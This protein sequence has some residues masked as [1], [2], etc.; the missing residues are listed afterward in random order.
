MVDA[1]LLRHQ[2]DLCADE[3][4]H[5]LIS[6]AGVRSGKTFA[7]CTKALKLGAAN[8]DLPILFVEPTYRM[9]K[10]VAVR[11]FLDIFEMWGIPYTYKKTDQIIRPDIMHEDGQGYGFDI[12]L[13]SAD[14]A[15]RLMGWTAA[16]AILDEAG[17]VDE[18][19]PK[20]LMKRVSHPL[21]KVRQLVLC[22]TPEGFNW[23]YEWAEGTPKAGSRLIRARTADNRHL[24]ADYLDGVLSYLS[25]EEIAQYT[26]GLFVPMGG[27]V[28]HRFRRDLHVRPCPMN[29]HGQP[30]GQVQMWC[31]F[32]I[33]TQAWA[34]ARVNGGEAHVFDEVV[35]EGDTQTHAERAVA[36]LHEYGIPPSIVDVYC[37]ATGSARKTSSTMSDVLLLKRAGFRNVL[38]NKANPPVRD[39]VAAVNLKLSEGALFFDPKARY[40][41]KC[42]EQQGRDE[43]GEPDKRSGLDHGADSVGYGVHFQWPV[44]YSARGNAQ[45]YH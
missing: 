44:R 24:S 17:Q 14:N 15:Q 29:E 39:R 10:D 40:H 20:E 26:E 13:R 9:L 32:N 22:G 42:I 37:D 23:F 16:A 1:A 30:G 7:A 21:A 19:I 33:S 2:L 25:E 35:G 41:L 5:P 12:V 3:Q 34:L 27:R 28:Y 11:C 6:V 4:S 36:K 31:D 45:R 8:G 43:G 38:H 18:S